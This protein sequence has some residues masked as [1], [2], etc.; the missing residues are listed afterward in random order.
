MDITMNMQKRLSILLM[1]LTT[2]GASHAV[3][4]DLGTFNGVGWI[5]I[6]DNLAVSAVACAV[7]AVVVG[8][9]LCRAA[10]AADACEEEAYQAILKANSAATAG[11]VA[12]AATHSTA[13][14]HGG[15][16]SIQAPP[17][18]HAVYTAAP[19]AATATVQIRG[20]ERGSGRKGLP[21]VELA[22]AP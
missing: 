20:I 10:A 1:L 4:D 12:K 11:T 2:S 13:T 17:S 15:E 16:T 22:E 7:I 5:W 21:A 3:K 18:W 19:R 14:Q 8:V 9:A 6:L